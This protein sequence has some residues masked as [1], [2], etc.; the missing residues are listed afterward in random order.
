MAW[1]HGPKP[2]IFC[3]ACLH[4]S[5]LQSI[6][7]GLSVAAEDH[8]EMG[9]SM[10]PAILSAA[11]VRVGMRILARTTKQN[12][13]TAAA[14]AV[15][16]GLLEPPRSVAG[17]EGGAHTTSR[18]RGWITRCPSLPE[19]NSDRYLV[20]GLGLVPKDYAQRKTNMGFVSQEQCKNSDEVTIR[21]IFS[22]HCLLLR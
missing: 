12:Q 17:Q 7:S 9:E 19:V 21:Q 18:S 2:C 15:A 5:E 3:C 10:T 4:C 16:V 20:T 8:L 14:A 1:D 13:Q 6:R 11:L 22:N